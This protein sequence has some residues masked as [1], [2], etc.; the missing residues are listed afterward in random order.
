MKVAISKERLDNVKVDNI[1]NKE[2]LTLLELSK[3]DRNKE[4]QEISKNEGN[5]EINKNDG[6]QEMR[7]MGAM[8]MNCSAT[9]RFG[10]QPVPRRRQRHEMVADNSLWRCAFA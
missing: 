5:Q 7:K 9:L 10:R 1:K 3:I 6:N 2:T 4:I 8:K